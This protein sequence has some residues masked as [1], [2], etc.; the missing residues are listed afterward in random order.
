MNSDKHEASDW[1]DIDD[2]TEPIKVYLGE[3]N[4]TC[5]G[6]DRH[7]Q[8]GQEGCDPQAEEA[9]CEDRSEDARSNVEKWPRESRYP[10]M[11]ICI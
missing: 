10:G 4:S 5:G 7:S 2:Y 11:P 6:E 3:Q 8:Q 1:H 9:A